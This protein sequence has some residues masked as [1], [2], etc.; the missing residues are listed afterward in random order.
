MRA[1]A[2]REP[3]IAAVL[4][5][6][7]VSACGHHDEPAPAPAPVAPTPRPDAASPPPLDAAPAKPAIARRC[8]LGGDPLADDCKSDNSGIA[9]DHAG[10]LYVVAAHDIRRYKRTGDCNFE[11]AGAP[12]GLPPETKRL[13]ALGKGPI[14]MRSGGPVWHL[15]SAGDAIYIV[16]YLAGMFR[17]DR[18]KAEPACTDEFGYDSVAVLGKRVVIARK[19][20]EQLALAGRGHCR[21]SSANIDAKASGKVFAVRD[22][23]YAG[24]VDVARY[25]G[26]TKVPLGETIHA[27]SV[28]GVVP[29]GSGTC[30]VDNNCMKL[31]E[32]AANGTLAHTLD[33]VALFATRPYA[34]A[35]ATAY[36]DSVWLLAKHRDRDTCETAVYEVP[37]SS[38]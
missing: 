26:A 25:D 30:V 9:F 19:G 35:S 8:T 28:V 15:A 27:C 37:F 4:A 2:R 17:I 24:F 5:M 3:S 21:A 16:D 36:G 20:I 18:G 23:L 31:I 22:T 13:Q 7:I 14:Y 6:L 33:D 1:V 32:L 29:C 11:L 38:L 10:T 12:I 34:L